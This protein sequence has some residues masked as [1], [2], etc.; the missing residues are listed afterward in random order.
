MYTARL[1]LGKR[2]FIDP[3]P[4]HVESQDQLD[5]VVELIRL[6]ME[7]RE[8]QEERERRDDVDDIHPN[9]EPATKKV[10]PV[11]T[12][13]VPPGSALRICFEDCDGEFEVHFDTYE[14]ERSI[15]VKET[16][17]LPGSV[18]GEADSILYEEF[19][20]RKD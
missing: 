12:V 7:E 15:I 14:H 6:H 5:A 3:L 8:E 19:F 11:T 18:K 13:T 17:G 4:C 10:S 1:D 9:R 2:T 20:G 16:A